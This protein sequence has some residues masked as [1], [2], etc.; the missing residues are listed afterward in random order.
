MWQNKIVEAARYHGWWVYHPYD[1]R[2]SQAG[3]PDLTLIRPPR[4]VFAE[5]KNATGIITNDQREVIELLNDCTGVEAY[6]WR[7]DDWPAVLSLLSRDGNPS[8]P[9]TKTSQRVTS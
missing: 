9:P 5:L 1:S 8:S 7:P 2:R 4:I 3:W 6:V